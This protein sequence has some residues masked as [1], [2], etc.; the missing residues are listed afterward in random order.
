RRHTRWP[1][2]W[3]SDVCSSDLEGRRQERP[4]IQ[5][6][7]GVAH[8]AD[9]GPVRQDVAARPGAGAVGGVQRV[10]YVVGGVAVLLGEGG[11]P[12]L[13][14]IGRASCRETVLVLVAA[15]A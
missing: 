13:V 15:V 4:L 2:D 7:H 8:G 3:S 12:A 11:G 6:E 9:V 10:A 5:G 1:H 14:E